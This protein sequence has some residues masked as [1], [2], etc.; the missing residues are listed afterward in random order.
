MLVRIGMS[1]NYIAKG[2]HE[3]PHEVWDRDVIE[4]AYT[5]TVCP[6]P[7]PMLA[8]KR[9]DGWLHTVRRVRTDKPYRSC[10]Y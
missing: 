1:L 2:L 3:R 8:V 10:E 7:T 9:F 5:H 6:G 4:T